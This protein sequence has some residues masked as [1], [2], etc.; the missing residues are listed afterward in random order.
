MIRGFKKS[1]LTNTS[2]CV[3]GRYV[4]LAA[5]LLLLP[6]CSGSVEDPA[7]GAS[8]ADIEEARI[9]SGTHH[10]R[11][12][13]DAA[14]VT[15]AD[16]GAHAD[17]AVGSDA[18]PTT[19]PKPADAGVVSTSGGNDAGLPPVTVPPVTVPPVTVPPVSA[20]LDSVWSPLSV[21]TVVN[22]MD[23]GAKGDGVTDDLN[24]LSATINA[25][26]D[27]G[28]IVYFPAGKSFKKT[29]LLVITKNHV[30]LWSVNRAAELFQSVAG[31]QR[32]QS[33]LCRS[34]T[35][36]GIFGLKLR[37]DG[38]ARF[39]A[40][41]DNQISADH[42]SLVEIAGNEIQ[43]SAAAGMFLYGSTEHYIEGNYVHHTWADHI[44]HTEGAT[45]SWVWGNYMF[46]E[47]P[48]KGDDGVACVTYGPTGRLCGDMEW[49]NNDMLGSGWGRGYS[50]IGGQN[51]NIHNNWATGVSAAG[52][53]IASEPSYN[54]ASSHDITVANNYIYKCALNGSQPGILVSGL[55]TAAAPLT[56]LTF[57]NNVSVGSPAGA[58]RAEGA[59]AN[60]VD[61][62]LLTAASAIPGAI[63]SISNV[64]L[65]DTSVLRTRDVSHV[66]ANVRP[67]LYRIHVRPAVSGSG[68]Q[69][70]FEYVVKGSPSDISTFAAARASAG[71]FVSEQRTVSG[72]AYALILCKAPLTIP[73]TLSAV[74]FRE[75]RSKDAV[76]QLDWL[77]KRVDAGS[78]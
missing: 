58:Y 46:N 72:T 33:T 52:V 31:Q 12:P 68:Y 37:S 5:A 64:K 61:N 30:K 6:A 28:G 40:L 35:G 50:V 57:S 27:A 70:R 76:N 14:V 54:S 21:M 34:N 11:H 16:S 55:N 62:N 42:A 2:N 56:N 78:Y 18:G 1:N 4:R 23:H 53:I 49:W 71:D 17:A 25:L 38:A 66:A 43:G 22:P 8:S 39:N 29:N 41:E 10:A 36:C 44:H 75:M 26:P 24:A 69:Q 63:P 13:A 59:Y 7:E 45:A 32:H 19:A 73:T 74:T 48:S 15:N 47:A 77:W 60:V 51:I 65:A 3:Q 9:W 67:G 20:S